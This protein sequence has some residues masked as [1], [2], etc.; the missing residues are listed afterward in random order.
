MISAAD[1]NF[2]QALSYS[3]SC[4]QVG[5]WVM[6]LLNIIMF[7]NYHVSY[8]IELHI[9]QKKHIDDHV[10]YSNI[11]KWLCK[12]IMKI[13]RFPKFKIIHKCKS[14]QVFYNDMRILKRITIYCLRLY[15]IA[16]TRETC[17]LNIQTLYNK[18]PWLI[19]VSASAS[20]VWSMRF[21]APT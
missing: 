11:Y 9:K 4:F 16:I 18:H 14:V 13:L 19:E 20:A 10:M 6:E 1:M 2:W 3:F 21:W 8:V 15:I 17:H 12:Y 5:S 7:I